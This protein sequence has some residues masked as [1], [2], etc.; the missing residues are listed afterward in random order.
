MKKII[1]EI[2]VVEGRDDINAVKNAVDAEVIQVNGFAVRK[3]ETIEKIKVASEKKGII[4]LT[5]PDYAG[6]EIRKFLHQ[7]FP[8]AKDAYIT[9]KEGSKDGDI[10]VENAQPE[11]I[12]YA[13]E[14]AKCTVEK[15]IIENF[16]TEDLFL[17]K[18]VGYPNSTLMR[19]KLGKILGI[20]YSNGKQLLSKLNRYGI[21]KEELK[22]A[23]EKISQ[24]E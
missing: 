11:A 17:Y 5:D 20:G 15:N 7:F 12:I 22:I 14:K 4:I 16:T 8:E 10:G 23:M 1:K 6:N 18:L 9:R 2:I 24:N 21:E 19:E 13:L 3:K